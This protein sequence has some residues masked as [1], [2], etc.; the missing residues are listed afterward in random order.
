MLTY[1]R[2]GRRY[3]AVYDS[4]D[5]LCVTV[6]KKGAI[7]VIQRVTRKGGAR[8]ARKSRKEAE[9]QELFRKKFTLNKERWMRRKRT[10]LDRFC[11]VTQ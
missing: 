7:A 8:P 4:D 11:A 6:Y 9:Q 5:L 2:Y 1:S 10:N 3:W